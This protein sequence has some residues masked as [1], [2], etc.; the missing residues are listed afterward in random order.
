MRAVNRLLPS[1]LRRLLRS[2]WILSEE[3]ALRRSIS[4][5]RCV[6]KAGV[7][8]PWYTFPAIEYLKSL[9][10]SHANVLE[11]GSGASSSWWADRSNSVKAVEHDRDWFDSVRR[12][13]KPNLNVVLA[14]DE[15][16]YLGA[17][18]GG[19][20]DVIVIDGVHRQRCAEIVPQALADGGLVILDNADWHPEAARILRERNALLQV[21]F[22]GFGPI[23]GYTWTTS[24]FFSRD[25]VCRPRDDRLPSYSVGA[26]RQ[27]A[28]QQ[29]TE[30]MDA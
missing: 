8:T 6:D 22:H 4:F 12:T 19:T 3:Y 17:F 9:D 10:F 27:L 1:T 28:G 5:G 23:N 21:D 7:E 25:F 15:S 24:L 16:A 14:E 11:F 18:A 20:F 13:Q 26:I 29:G 30:R 2:F